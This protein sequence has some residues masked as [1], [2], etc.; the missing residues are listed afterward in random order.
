MMS[1]IGVPSSLWLISAPLAATAATPAP[2]TLSL[3]RVRLFERGELCGE[4]WPMAAKFGLC[5]ALWYGVKR[6]AG[7]FQVSS[8]NIASR[9]GLK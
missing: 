1:S 7:S 5:C 3:R 6:L 4:N 2:V 9:S 8:G